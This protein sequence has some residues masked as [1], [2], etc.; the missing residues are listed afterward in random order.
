MK[1]LAISGS[2]RK[3]GNTAIVLN[4]ILNELKSIKTKKYK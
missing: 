1:V 3:D 4:T 2:S